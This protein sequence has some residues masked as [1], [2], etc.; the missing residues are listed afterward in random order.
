[1]REMCGAIR[2]RISLRPRMPLINLMVCRGH[3]LTPQQVFGER[4]RVSSRAGE[5]MA[6][7]HVRLRAV[8]QLR[9]P[10]GRRR[11]RNSNGCGRNDPAE[12]RDRAHAGQ[13]RGPRSSFAGGSGDALKP[14]THIGP[15]VDATQLEQDL[16]YVAIGQAEG[17]RLALGGERLNRATPGFYMA[18]ALFLDA[19][20]SMR[21]SRE[22]IFGPVSTMIPAHDYDHALSIANDTEFGLCAGICTTSL[23]RAS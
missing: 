3:D 14:G 8:I 10:V 13:D 1:M 20:N 21:I 2:T 5:G 7:F 18:P 19:D 12:S 6:A 16:A 17:A 11:P 22:E 4:R 15:V 9:P 23:K